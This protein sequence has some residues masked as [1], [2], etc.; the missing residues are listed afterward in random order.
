[1]DICCY[2]CGQEANT[3]EHVPP[4]CLFPERKDL[5][6]GTDLR[7]NLITVP[8]CEEHN[9]KKSGD[10]EYLMYVLAMNLPSGRTGSQHFS[11]K[12]LRAIQRRP[13]L[14]NRV[15][16]KSTPVTLH[17]PRTNK[18]YETLAIEAEGERLERVLE[19][20]ALGIYRHHFER[21][22]NGPL[23]VLPEFLHFLPDENSSEWNQ[24]IQETTSYANA[25]FAQSPSYGENSEIFR[26]QVSEGASEAPSAIRMHFYGFSRVLAVYGAA[27]A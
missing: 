6:A 16:S 17:D 4:Q 21:N 15:L 24:A 12:V 18:P 23:R 22:W 3:T 11:T 14:V 2:C 13:N 25:L 20:V 19:K 26:Y 5:P 27:G 1:M 8:S 7:R 9:L 10:D